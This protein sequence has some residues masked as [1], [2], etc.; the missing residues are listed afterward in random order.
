MIAAKMAAVG[1]RS[2][3]YLWVEL[4][5]IFV[6]APAGFA[7][8]Q[9]RGLLIVG[10][11]VLAAGALLLLL[12]DRS[13]DRR[14]LVR[15]RGLKRELRR[16]LWMFV[17]LGFAMAVLMNKLMPEAFC[18]FPRERPVLWGAIMLLYPIFSV[19]PQ[20]VIWRSFFLHRYRRLIGC[21]RPAMVTAA[22]MFGY[23]HVLFLN[24]VAPALTFAGGLLFTYTHLRARSLP[25]AAVEHAM[26][27]CLAFTLGYGQF[28]YTGNVQ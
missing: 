10:M 13:Y 4:L 7:L 15:L 14:S 28:L 20:S 6:A 5:A 2:T 26:Y 9:P 25:I 24:P 22:M 23:A 8:F 19:L 16:I 1:R 12:T 21:G 3:P 27:G 11:W 17:P 18:Y